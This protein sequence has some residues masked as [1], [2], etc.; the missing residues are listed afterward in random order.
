MS[1]PVGEIRIVL[2]SWRDADDAL[3][4]IESFA[5]ARRRMAGSG[6]P[7]SLVVVDNGGSL[8]RAE[9]LAAWPEATLLV[10]DANRG[11]GPAA[12]QGAQVPGGDVL[13][14]LNPDTRAV[15]EPFGAIAEAFDS[16]PD[17]VA[18]APRLVDEVEGRLQRPRLA[19]PGR[20]D[21]FT[22]Q[23]RRLPRL[24][25]DARELLLIDS[26]APNNRGRRRFRYAD[27]DPDA[28]LEVEQAAGA[29]LAVRRDAFDEVKG[30]DERFAPAWF[31]DVDLCARLAEHGS[32]LYWPAARFRHRGG[33]S[34]GE[35]GYRR[36]LPIYYENAIRYRRGRYGAVSRLAYR[37]LLVGGM[38]LRLAALPFRRRPPRPRSESAAAYLRVVTVALGLPGRG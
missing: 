34:S 16:R 5:V 27:R 38:G 20:E 13:L 30:F 7:V 35:L 29:A 9:V 22:F 37:A 4:A 24:A 31:E 19:P 6:P 12:N 3:A 32:I 17:L 28:P 2:V 26:V 25:D 1:S 21:Q 14:F 8:P 33:A 23:L 15:G 36:F 10:N 11:F 18:V